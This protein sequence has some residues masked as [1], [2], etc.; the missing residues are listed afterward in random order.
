MAKKEPKPF[1]ERQLKVGEAIKRALAH[2][3]Q[4][5]IH[6]PFLEQNPVVI[7]EVRMTADLKTAKIYILPMIG[8]KDSHK[9]FVENITAI[10]HKLKQHLAKQIKLRYTPEL[11]F[12]LDYS[13]EHVSHINSLLKR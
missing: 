11:L 12:Y 13:F 3:L 8:A 9:A 7:S 5:D 10:A 6:E 1:S 2:I 4:H